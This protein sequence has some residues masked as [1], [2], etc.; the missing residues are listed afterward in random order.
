VAEKSNCDYVNNASNALAS[1]Y[2][3]YFFLN[4]FAILNALMPAHQTSRHQHSST[5]KNLFVG[6]VLGGQTIAQAALHFGLKDSTAR[7]KNIIQWAQPKTNPV[8]A[9]P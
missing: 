7:R 9:V 8:L 4:H 3:V 6:A 1:H 5:K 2:S